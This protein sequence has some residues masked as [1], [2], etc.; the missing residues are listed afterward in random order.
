MN[1]L[2]T[3]ILVLTTLLVFGLAG[4]VWAQTSSNYDNSWHVLSA[5]GSAG[6][7]LDGR[8]ILGT[9][10]QFAI[11]PAASDQISVVSGFWHGTLE[12]NHRVYLPVVLFSQ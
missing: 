5:G 9:L 7:T 1:R 10:G 11:S 12:K 8:T 3:S 4:I 6:M 2:R